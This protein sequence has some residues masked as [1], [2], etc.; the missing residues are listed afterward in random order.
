MAGQED[1]GMIPPPCSIQNCRRKISERECQ[2]TIFIT[3]GRDDEWQRLVGIAGLESGFFFFFFCI[4]SA[5][6]WP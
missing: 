5:E 1:A 4:Y 2:F 3:I 6:I